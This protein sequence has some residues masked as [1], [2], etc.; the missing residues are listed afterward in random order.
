MLFLL[1]H[2]CG[3]LYPYIAN[4]CCV[5]LRA[6]KQ[7]SRDHIEGSGVNPLKLPYCF[8]Y[9]AHSIIRCTQTFLHDF[10]KLA[11]WKLSQNIQIQGAVSIFGYVHLNFNNNPL[12][13][14]S[15]PPMWT[16]VKKAQTYFLSK[17]RKSHL[18]TQKALFSKVQILRESIFVP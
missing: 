12:S 15:L 9:K 10:S 7:G 2:K 16:K 11:N 8:S 17:A 6:V 1:H 18:P 3:S 13:D 5:Q 4:P 14:Y